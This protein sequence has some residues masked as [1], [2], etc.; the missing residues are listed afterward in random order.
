LNEVAKLGMNFE[1]F[2]AA[3][4][5]FERFTTDQFRPPLSTSMSPV[6]LAV[7]M[8]SRAACRLL[9]RKHSPYNGPTRSGDIQTLATA[10]QQF[11]RVKF[12]IFC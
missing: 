11:I 8:A 2:F 12:G 3:L 6:C 4:T 10:L 7:V 5:R 9:L 1:T